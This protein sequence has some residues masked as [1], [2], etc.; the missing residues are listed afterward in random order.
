MFGS[1][2]GLI[3]IGG[4]IGGAAKKAYYDASVLSESKERAIREGRPYYCDAKHRFYLTETGKRVMYWRTGKG[5]VL[6]SYAT[7]ELLYR[8]KTVKDS[9]LIFEWL[10]KVYRSL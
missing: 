6:Y 1:I 2:L 5:Y 4:A 8:T 3:G 10:P 7:G 9:D